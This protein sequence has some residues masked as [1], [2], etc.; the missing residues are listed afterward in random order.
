[1]NKM[2]GDMKPFSFSDSATPLA[3]NPAAVQSIKPEFIRL[4]LPGGRCRYTGL[5]RTTLCELAIPS[6][7]NEFRPPV[8]S[9][10]IRKRGAQRGI[11]LINYDS[12]L[13]YLRN[14]N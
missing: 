7:T 6:P 3:A 1:M 9:V 14:L 13:D 12:L 11:R 8:K 2:T 10:L 4:P 5:S